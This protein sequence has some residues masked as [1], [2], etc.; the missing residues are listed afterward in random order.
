MCAQSNAIGE[1]RRFASLKNVHVTIVIHPRKGDEAKTL[2][3]SSIFGSVRASQEA[4][5]VM[6]LQA[7]TGDNKHLEVWN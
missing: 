4:D 5:N 3:T 7:R 6:I 1:F 2:T